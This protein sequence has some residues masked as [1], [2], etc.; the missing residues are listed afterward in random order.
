MSYPI[1][2]KT[3]VRG[4]Y[5]RKFGGTKSRLF[6]INRHVR[7]S[8]SAPQLQRR[9]VAWP[10]CLRAGRATSGKY[11]KMTTRYTGR[12]GQAEW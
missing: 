11:K 8:I 12:D 9:R 4:K 7:V 5:D 1:V 3:S 2:S 6:R 10:V